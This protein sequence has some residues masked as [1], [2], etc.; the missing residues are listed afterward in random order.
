M[1]W[2]TKINHEI[3][4]KNEA[5]RRLALQFLAGHLYVARFIHLMIIGL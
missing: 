3:D 4:K 5:I 1:S 2:N